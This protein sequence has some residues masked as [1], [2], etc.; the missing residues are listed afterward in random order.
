MW[1]GKGEQPEG[2][3]RWVLGCNLGSGGGRDIQR[4]GYW[5]KE[6]ELG[7]YVGVFGDC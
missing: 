4:S 5:C 6:M 3:Y 1:K 2:D 7:K